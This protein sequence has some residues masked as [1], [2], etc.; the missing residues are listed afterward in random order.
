[1]F[2]IH[3]A[4]C[5]RLEGN[6]WNVGPDLFGI[7][8]HTKEVTLA[9]IL[10]PNQEIMPGF[11]AVSVKTKEGKTVS[12]ILGSETDTSVTIRQALGVET[13]ILRSQIEKLTASDLSLMPDGLE[14]A[15][16]RQQMADLLA[17][18]KGE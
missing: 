15:M 12:G 6:G 11:E 7:R 13:N 9:H 2:A 1:M 5:H 10:V 3:C 14:Q 4:S 16:T 17:F 8:N 18:L